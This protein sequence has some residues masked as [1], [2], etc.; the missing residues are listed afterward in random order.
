L[1]FENLAIKGFGR[2]ELRNAKTGVLDEWTEWENT[3]MQTGF[4]DFLVSGLSADLAD[5]ATISHGAIG[6]TT[7]APDSTN[8]SLSGEFETRRDL[9]GTLSSVGTLL[10]TWS[11]ATNEATQSQVARVGM[12][13][14]STNGKMFSEATFTASTKTTDQTLAISYE[15]RFS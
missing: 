6:S 2:L 1:A 12:F 8:T 9:T 11:Y 10:N 3:V 7:T 15:I 4:D 13:D 5:G 14:A